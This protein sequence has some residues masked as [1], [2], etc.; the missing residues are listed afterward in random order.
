MVARHSAWSRIASV[1][2]VMPLRSLLI[3]SHQQRGA[4]SGSLFL[5]LG[6][7]HINCLWGW[8]AGILH[9][10][11]PLKPSLSQLVLHWQLPHFLQDMVGFCI[12]SHK[13]ILRMSQT[14][15]ILGNCLHPDVI[16]LSVHS[17]H[18]L[19]LVCWDSDNVGVI[20]KAKD[21]TVLPERQVGLGLL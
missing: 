7:H 5:P 8:W 13:V 17:N 11:K 3:R 2:F 19:T 18:D 12:L 9:V 21:C 6:L 16:V 4:P 10:S 15:V 20:T 1:Q 14:L